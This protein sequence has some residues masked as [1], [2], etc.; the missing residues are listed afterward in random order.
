MI[1]NRSF[2]YTAQTKNMG[3]FFCFWESYN[4]C[5]D[6]ALKEVYHVNFTDR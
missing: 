1:I 2:S 6:D 4:D 5:N 3:T